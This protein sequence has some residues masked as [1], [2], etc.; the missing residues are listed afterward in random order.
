MKKLVGI[1][2]LGILAVFFT[3]SIASATPYAF[4]DDS[5]YWPGWNNNTSDDDTDVIGTPDFLG[6]T[7]F[8]EYDSVTSTQKLTQLTISAY[9]PTENWD[10]LS[11]GDLFIS[12]DGDTNWEYVV[13]LTTSNTWTAPAPDD[14]DNVDPIGDN[15]NIYDVDIPL[16]TGNY[17]LSG[18][19]LTSPWTN[20]WIRDDHPVAYGGSLSNPPIGAVHFSGWG[21]TASTDPNNPSLFEFNFAQLVGG[22]IDVSND[23]TFGWT[24][25]CAN[26]VLYET[27]NPV[28]EPATMLLLGTGLIGLAGIGR[29]KIKKA[30][31]S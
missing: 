6:G 20:Y 30:H 8:I 13:D 19:D 14:D 11:P 26:D 12:N 4:G 29:K 31:S 15:Y 3:A 5:I 1:L 23:F 2:I 25:N 18:K 10:I 22:G 9:D 27:V 24:T 28:P 17:T 21:D 7:A 16:T